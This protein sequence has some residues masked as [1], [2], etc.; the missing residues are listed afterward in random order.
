MTASSLPVE[1]TSYVGRGGEIREIIEL[2]ETGRRLVTLTGP[3]GVG[4]TRLAQRVAAGA[5]S[6]FDGDVAFIELAELREPDLLISTVAHRLE[7][8]DN[9]T[10]PALDVLTRQLRDRRMLLVLDNCEHLLSACARLAE[11][12]L[13]SCPGMAMLATSRQSLDVPGEHLVPVRPFAVPRPGLSPDQVSGYDAV[14][15]LIDRATAAAAPLS[16]TEANAADVVRLCRALDG[17]PLA[18]EL[19][20]VRLRALSA[21]QLAD[22]LDTRLAML[23]GGRRVSARQQT[24]QALLDWSY[25][26][27]TGQEKLLW[28]RT[29]VF[30]GSFDLDAAEDV[31]SGDGI[32]RE[33]VLDGLDGLIDKSI[34]LREGADTARYRLL[35]T[36]RHYGEDRLVEQ[37]GQHLRRR[38]HRDHYRR[39][40]DRFAAEWFGPEQIAWAAWID[41][42]NAN[43]R[44][45]L[46]FCTADPAEAGTGLRMAADVWNFWV[47]VS[48]KEGRMWFGRLL[49]AAP[50]DAPG[51]ATGLLLHS[52]F[53]NLQGDTDT[54]AELDAATRIAER[55]GDRH[56]AS[57]V[58]IVAGHGAMMRD[59]ASE[60]TTSLEDAVATLRELG[61]PYSIAWGMFTLG[62]CTGLAG[63]VSRSREVL[64]AAIEMCVEHGDLFLRSW[65]LWSRSAIE[66]AHGDVQ[67]AKKAA[68]EVLRLQRS[69]HD[70]SVI[71]YTL[72]VLAGC[73][74]RTGDARRAARLSG[75]ASVMW[76][77][78]GATITNLTSFS[79]HMHTATAAV[80]KALGQDKAAAEFTAGTAMSTAQ[81]IS[82]A[83]D[84]APDQERAPAPNLSGL[85]KRES[86]IARQVAEGMTNREIAAHFV[87]APRTVDTHITNIMNKLGVHTRTKIAT[88]VLDSTPG[89]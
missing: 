49:D 73:A 80:V 5:A 87:I 40:T 25:D 19:A 50:A 63:N 43:L 68:T 67:V 48:T 62:L 72:T 30:A 42:E 83:L 51:K 66:Y 31:C 26:L 47:R 46:D 33:A 61:R 32:E 76:R 20:A 65:T 89:S 74:A 57:C 3:G 58:L 6:A 23:R 17:L 10:A 13:R 11:A 44:L 28:A 12:L 24:F 71:G 35:E 34:L 38:L 14:R 18:I 29:S 81:A 54:R 27:C 70:R 88:W 41:R 84:D 8:G 15:L 39:L 79:S 37:D 55:T 82:Y 85:T 4:K 59:R 52:F 77:S 7:L 78:V 22:R 60:V 45:A 1:Q 36:V 64:D 16:V 86:D 9:T 69:L 2:I 75:A 56:A 21:G 53:A